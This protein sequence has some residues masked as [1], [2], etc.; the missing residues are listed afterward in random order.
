[1]QNGVAAKKD[2]KL[3]NIISGYHPIQVL[4]SMQKREMNNRNA[5]QLASHNINN[6]NL[7]NEFF[8]II[9]SI[10]ERFMIEDEVI[11]LTISLADNALANFGND[12]EPTHGIH[13][14]YACLDLAVKYL[15][16]GPTDNLVKTILTQLI[17]HIDYQY[18]LSIQRQVLGVLGGSLEIPTPVT[19]QKLH[20]SKGVLFPQI[21]NNH[22]SSQNHFEQANK[23]VLIQSNKKFLNNLTRYANAF[24]FTTT[25]DVDFYDT[26]PSK[27]A[28][29]AILMARVKMSLRDWWPPQLE[30]ITMYN[31][32]ELLRVC[33]RIFVTLK[34]ANPKFYQKMN[35][36]I[37]LQNEANNTKSGCFRHIQQNE[38]LGESFISPET[39]QQLNNYAQ[40]PFK[41]AYN[42]IEN[43]LRSPNIAKKWSQTFNFQTI[44]EVLDHKLS[45]SFFFSSQNSQNSINQPQIN[46]VETPPQK[47]SSENQDNEMD[48]Q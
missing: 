26:P 42:D 43:L 46:L 22:M 44:S 31:Q 20:L 30:V 29:A 4:K 47:N 38:N 15:Q 24:Q 7:R 17:E 45:Q 34:S 10:A 2:Y 5:W 25:M 23:C 33:D 3:K 28:A 6:I 16:C 39:S 11:Y 35:H 14:F 41:K 21:D 27:L 40:K 18:L 13:I 37:N 8:P 12:L 36:D 32:E 19:F 48:Y 9:R 1:M